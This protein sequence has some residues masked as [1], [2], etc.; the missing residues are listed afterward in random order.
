MLFIEPICFPPPV[1]LSVTALCPSCASGLLSLQSRALPLQC[2]APLNTV[3]ILTCSNLKW[4]AYTVHKAHSPPN[5][6]DTAQPSG[7]E[8]SGINMEYRVCST[9]VLSTAATWK[10]IKNSGNFWMDQCYIRTQLAT[11]TKEKSNMTRL[12]DR[13]EL[14]KNNMGTNCA[15]NRRHK[16]PHNLCVR[17]HVNLGWG[18]LQSKS[19]L[20]IEFCELLPSGDTGWRNRPLDVQNSQCQSQQY[21]QYT[22]NVTLCAHSCN[23]CC[24]GK[25]ISITYSECVFVALGIQYAMRMCHIVIRSPSRSTIFSHIIS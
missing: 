13:S 4:P 1:V 12:H 2:W 10:V 9:N 16:M 19:W 17:S 8:V 21:T 18:I 5:F 25:A 6:S 14:L 11:G 3:S 23:H 7:F 20:Q 22:Y 15:G 24:S